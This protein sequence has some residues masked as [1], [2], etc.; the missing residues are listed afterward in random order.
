MIV[1]ASTAFGKTAS[2]R[3]SSS[4]ARPISAAVNTPAIR[5]RLP[6]SWLTMLRE[7]LPATGMP[8]LIAAV[9]LAAARPASSRRGSTRAP[10]RRASDSATTRLLTN[11][12]SA[13]SRAL[14][15]MRVHSSASNDG[16]SMRGARSGNA[17]TSATP[18]APASVS[19]ATAIASISTI[20][21]TKRAS[22]A[23]RAGPTTR[24]SAS[25]ACR[26][27]SHSASSAATP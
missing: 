3:P 22:S 13:I 5:V 7:K 17:P 21:G 23:A 11:A 16:Q 18:C 27:A 6:A 8:A 10:S 19:S 4:I 25:A 14:G 9:R 2:G 12:T 1:A 24:V 20:S 15:S 26:R